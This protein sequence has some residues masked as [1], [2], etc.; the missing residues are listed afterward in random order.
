[1]KCKLVKLNKLSGNKASIYTVIIENENNEFKES[2][3][4]KFLRENKNSF[5]SEIK[6]IINRLQTIGNDTGAR[7]SFFKL[8]EGKPGDGVCALYDSPSKNLRL[9]GIRYGSELIIIG[10]GGPK[11]KNIRTLQE[12]DKLKK[13]NYFLRWLS[14]KITEAR[15]NGDMSFTYD[16]MD[17]KG[18]L[19][20]KDDDEE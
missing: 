17:F 19:I 6:D 16:F 7:D 12:S 15:G 9:Y 10:G 11:P 4:D 13:E 3:F 2:L 8:K 20:I 18:D 14:L 1:M 5:S